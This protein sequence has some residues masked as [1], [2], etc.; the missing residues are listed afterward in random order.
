MDRQTSLGQASTSHLCRTFGLSRQALH[1]ASKPRPERQPRAPR[2]GPWLSVEVLQPAIEK[3]VQEHPA[4]GVRKIWAL[5]RSEGLQASQKRIYALM[6][7]LGLLLPVSGGERLP[8]PRGHVVV[9]DSN[10]RWATALTTVWTKQDG[11]V[12]V[13]PVV[14]CGDR[15]CLA[16]HV[17]LSQE[18]RA[19]LAPVREACLKAF[20]QP[21][22]VPYDM[23]LR[24]DH[25]T[26]YT[27]SDCRDFCMEWRL[28][29]TFAPVG[30]PT[31][32]AVAERLIQTLK[33]ECIWLKDW[34]SRAELQAA[35]DS[36]RQ[37]YN[38][39]RPHQALGWRTPQ[40]Q[41]DKNLANNQPVTA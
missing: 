30:R 15:V 9:P 1:A 38:T 11:V 22:H 13:A 18:A 33:V 35:L 17:S 41:R 8:G 5:L 36:W 29:H 16:L 31:G 2:K 32:N 6:C 27:A 14:D 39:R 25:G 21:E 40:Q 24:T 37:T 4:W 10:R 3:A 23:E 12:A 19:M 7:S 20:G 34:E 26:Q 28:D